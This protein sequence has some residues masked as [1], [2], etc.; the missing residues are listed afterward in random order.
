MFLVLT[1]C[2]YANVSDSWLLKSKWQRAF[3]AAAGMYVELVIAS[4]AVFVWWFSMPGL[5]HHLSLNIIVVCSISTLL[6]NANPLLRYDGYYI[7]ADILEIPNL[8]QK[9][10]AMLNRV[11][12]KMFLGIET[13]E[14]P[15]CLLYT[16]DAAD[17]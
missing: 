12:G 13:A 7:L 1:P 15:F 5:V 2:L 4:I 16:S 10:S 17:E 6:F 14:D 11:S 8:R 3:I 9:S